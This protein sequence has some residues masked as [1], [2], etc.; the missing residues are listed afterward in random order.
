MN[1]TQFGPLF[2]TSVSSGG[3]LL[4]VAKN[5][6]DDAVDFF[7]TGLSTTKVSNQLKWVKYYVGLFC[8]LYSYSKIKYKYVWNVYESIITC[9]F[10][11][12]SKSPPHN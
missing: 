5:D 4:Q 2:E 12:I 6:I 9:A 8:M 7:S 3:Q 1:P 11:L 10:S